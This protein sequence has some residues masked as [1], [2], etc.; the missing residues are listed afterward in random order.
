MKVSDINTYKTKTK[1]KKVVSNS[2]RVKVNLV[3]LQTSAL[4][5]H[6]VLWDLCDVEF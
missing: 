5:V 1:K 4:A 2:S 3:L 6:Y